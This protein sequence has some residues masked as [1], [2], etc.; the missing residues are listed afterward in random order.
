MRN[1]I[2]ILS[3]AV[4]LL[5]AVFSCKT[6][7]KKNTL[8]TLLSP[9]ETGI[10]F[11][12]QLDYDKDF[13]VYRYRNFYN[14]G[15]VAVGDINND[16]L[17]DVYMGSNM[18]D[19]KLYLN[20][21]NFHFEDITEKAGVAG[22][23]K[24]STGVTMADVNGDGFL[25][26][27]V[28]NSG[29]VKGDSREN[30][31]FIN[32]GNLTFTEKAAE[33]GLADRG[34]S[35][36]AAF[37]DYDRDGDLDMYLL[38]N[39]FR[40]IG[41]FDFRKN[42][43]PKRD[44][45][46][47]D[48]LF[49]NDGNHF[50]DVSEQAGIYGSVIGFGLGVAIGD[51]NRDGWPDIYVSNDFFE[52]DYLYI[53]KG[54]G[55]FK[56][57]LENEIRHCSAA[58]M[59]SDLADVNNDGYPDIF[60]TDMLPQT[61]YRLKTKTTFDSWNNYK[62][63]Y[64]DNGYY[65]QFTRNMLQINNRDNTF[66]ELGCYAGVEATDWSW[67][68]LIAD[69]DN[70]GLKDIFVANGI[71]K[72]LTDQDFIQFIS[73]DETKRSMI[74]KEGVDYKK[75]L[76][77]I[78][79]EAIPNFAFSNNGNLTFTNKSSEWGLDTPGFSNG[80][81][82]ADLDNDG[83]LDLVV[84]NVNNPSWV[85]RNNAEKMHK[86]N[87]WLKVILKGD[88]K[89]PDA[90]GA[91]LTVKA[92]GKAFYLEQFP[93]RGFESTV[94]NRP[95][96]GLG[97]VQMID[98]LIVEWPNRKVQVLSNLKP[99]QVITVHQKDA[100]LDP[101]PMPVPDP[102]GFHFQEVTDQL[103]IPYRHQEDTYSD[104]DHDRLVYLMLSAEG[105]KICKGDVNG[106]GREDIYACGAHGQAGQLL[107]QQAN[108]TFA[109]M[110]E[111]AFIKDMQFE[112]T[113]A[114]FFDADGDKDL[115]LYVGSGGN[116][117]IGTDPINVDD[118]LYLNDGKGHFTR[119]ESA[120][121]GGK[122]VATSCVRVAD[123]DQD[124]DLD[125]FAGMRIIPGY[126]GA[127]VSSFVMKND[128]KGHFSNAT[129]QVAPDLIRMGM[130]TDAI[131]VD[132]DHDKDLDLVT[133][134]DYLPVTVFKNENGFLAKQQKNGLDM[135]N[136]WWRSIT[137]GDFDN[138]GDVD[139]VVGNFGANSRFRASEKE[140]VTMYFKDFDKNGTPEQILCRYNEG[141]SYP[142]VLRHDL[143]SQIPS[144]KKKY[145][146]YSSYALQKVDDIFTK[147]ELK[148]ALFWK[149]YHM[150]SV[151]LINDGK[152]NFTMNVLPAEA[153]YSPIYGLLVDDF[154]GDGNLDILA[155]GNFFEA[156]PE[157]GRTDA[158]YGLMLKGDGKGGFTSVLSKDSGFRVSGEVRKLLMIKEGKKKLVLA[159]RNNEA[160]Q[161]FRVK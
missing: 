87:H 52:R 58:S 135:S 108:G 76:D 110:E 104:F 29:D 85:Y 124:G 142:M 60:A 123:F 147:D 71:Y 95:N 146:K 114:V 69:L 17:P 75:L 13:N 83:D 47:G 115:D 79:S 152:G 30:E 28:C 43:R 82:Y 117:F 136:G 122:P 45:L 24:W 78:P 56:E 145:L 89:N 64:V 38:N 42:E 116:E 44:S 18:H 5:V 133:V 53:N 134:G 105:P 68:G 121:P 66:D 72:D 131:W 127:D 98:S 3:T 48:K 65:H 22:K 62:F 153:Q 151:V 81:A 159:A 50:T 150:E 139:F 92:G 27:Y 41:S 148:D 93:A 2:L 96:F 126:Y 37:F 160:L 103:N 36:H 91:K 143:V 33:Y 74:T 63:N 118:R 138:D 1:Y 23:K 129:Q 46:G 137:A 84:N 101:E 19:N 6:E 70:N 141:V 16:G 59:G 31:L 15:G 61:E 149:A 100:T 99:N 144:L 156:R 21:G 26:I 102:A 51:I 113:D 154:D 94:D 155:A 112:D 158:N 11:T 88:G 77:I 106:D 34:L 7:S 10:D 86:E 14:G 125:I 35:T 8:F 80:S 157:I 73:D 130:V 49:R 111:E 140:P 55:T 57:D 25:D 119:D 32:N 109:N 39:S 132:I 128:G 90:F 161:V 12:N 54:D 120:I 20:K 40:A 97:A 107:I 4:F 67:G 9:S